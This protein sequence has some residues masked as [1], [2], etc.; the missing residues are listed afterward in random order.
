[1]DDDLLR[2][3]RVIQDCPVMDPDVKAGAVLA[4]VRQS[5]AGAG[6]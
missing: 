5:L 1:M 2:A 3:I 6:V 4:L